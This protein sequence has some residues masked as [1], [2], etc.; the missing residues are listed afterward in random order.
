MLYRLRSVGERTYGIRTRSESE[1]EEKRGRPEK[2][3]AVARNQVGERGWRGTRERERGNVVVDGVIRNNEGEASG[4]GGEKQKRR[5]GRRRRR[6]C[7]AWSEK[8]S[9]GAGAK[10]ATCG[11]TEERGQ[12]EGGGKRTA[13]NLVPW[14]SSDD[15]AAAATC[16]DLLLASLLFSSSAIAWTRQ[17]RADAGAGSWERP[18]RDMNGPSDLQDETDIHSRNRGKHMFRDALYGLVLLRSF[19]GTESVLRAAWRR[20]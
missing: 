4:N 17:S 16:L 8:L 20:G 13:G 1:L 11:S 14:F 15:A 9:G 19:G 3:A 12:R 2:G 10:Q 6:G 5:R 18:A 7:R